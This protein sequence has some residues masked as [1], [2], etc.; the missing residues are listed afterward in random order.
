MGA[1]TIL[2]MAERV[3]ALLEQRLRVRGRSLSAQ[4]RKAGRRLPRKVRVAAGRL[5]QAADLAQNPKLLGRVDQAEVARAFD[6]CMDYLGKLDATGA[7][8]SV[9]LGAAA[10]VAFAMLVVIVMALGVIYWRGLV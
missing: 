8:R 3:S 7:K 1:M 5:G 4:V 10:S 9:W 2:Q 6:I